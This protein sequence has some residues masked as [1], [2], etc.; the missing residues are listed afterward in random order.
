MDAMGTGLPAVEPA[1]SV[2]PSY[3]RNG[4]LFSCEPCR[5][6][7]LR[8][9]H[10]SPVCG[11]CAKRGK[12]DQCIYHPAP[13]TKPR[14][15]PGIGPHRS[16]NASSLASPR[17]NH[18]GPYPTISRESHRALISP[19]TN[20]S[21][22]PDQTVVRRMQSPS[23]LPNTQSTQQSQWGLKPME[24]S[25]QLSS[26][27]SP[28]SATAFRDARTGFLGPTSY[29]AVYTENSTI[30]NTP[31]LNDT[32]NFPAISAEK[33]QQGAEVLSLLR[34]IP[35]YRRFTDRWFELCDG[36][37]L[38]RPVTQ[39]LLD[40]L[41]LEF[42]PILEEGRPEELLSLS[43]L[44]WRNTREPMK[45]RGDMTA[46]DWAHSASGRNLRW[47]SV[48]VIL[49]LVGLISLS[50]N[51]WDA[52]FESI[53]E[54]YVDRATF[55]ERMRKASEYC[56]C[57][58]Y[59]SEV[60]ND[61]YLCF[62][63]ED[64]VLV[65]C[66][67][68]DAHWAAWQ[69]TGE[70]CDAVIAMG[71]HQGNNPDANTPFFLAELRKKIFISAYGH[72]KVV[73]TFMGRPPR[74]SYRYCKMDWPLDLNDDQLFSEGEEL[75]A[76]LAGLDA[77]G[78]NT[79]G[80]LNRNCWSRIWFQHCR[81]RED[82]LEIALGS[83]EEDILFRS[84]QVRQ[85]MER[86][87][88]SMPAFMQITPEQIFASATSLINGFGDR[89]VNVVF[90]LNVHTG[91]V[92]TEFLL[93]RAV[94]SR[95][96][97]DTKEL[98]PTSR[99]MLKLV[100]LAQSRKDLFKDF[101]SDLIYLL[102]LHGVPAAG[103]LAVEMLK[104]EQTK[105]YTPEIL[106]RSETVQDLSV[107]ISALGTVG[108]GEGNFSICDQGRRAL[109]RVLDQILSPN[110]PPPISATGE[111]AIFDDSSLNFPIG[112]DAEFLQWLET[113]EWDKSHWIDPAMQ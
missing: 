102:A 17:Q 49:S 5:R 100:L 36:I 20:S 79:S 89:Q 6:G 101:Q 76:A 105:Q 67:K 13:L 28:E 108:P 113:V 55:A 63:F 106:P 50:L 44:V 46:R 47:E 86:T 34:D 16:A 40:G 11:R 72:D 26:Y 111:P 12:S 68:G 35:V 15:C 4:K 57:F 62:M 73:A 99:R 41:W 51:N 32:P 85:R 45:V 54:R 93:Q 48:G 19:R 31:D 70:V 1:V 21:Q 98:I 8:C 42:G 61:I 97:T 37:I 23:S 59:E 2:T 25:R 64:L 22:S 9:D 107:F 14:T 92:H 75:E 74:L 38:T 10:T 94:I 69:R 52:I 103:V 43:E 53:R 65:E 29:S 83:D 77:N 3:R 33:L 87:C 71:L 56:L 95:L 91:M 66:L 7:K 60:L 58:C 110:I 88:S 78:W 112:N 81:I 82:I 24:G 84:E 27:A 109:K 96:R 30:L 80:I 104:Q 90:L 18:T 39:C